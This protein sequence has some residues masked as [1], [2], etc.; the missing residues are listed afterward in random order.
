MKKH[1]TFNFIILVASLATIVEISC[2]SGPAKPT[3]QLL[4]AVK[5]ENV[6][7]VRQLI[8]AG[9]DVNG[10]PNISWKPIHTAVQ[11]KN[12]DIVKLLISKNADVNPWLSSYG[13]RRR[14]PLHMA[15]DTNDLEIAKVLIL[16][17]ADVN[18][19][20]I[21]KSNSVNNA[22]PPIFYARKEM[23][24]LL[25]DSGADVNSR[26]ADA[27]EYTPLHFA[28]KGESYREADIEIV[29]MLID[30]GADVNAASRY[31]ETPLESASKRIQVSKYVWL[32][33]R[34]D[35]ISLLKQHGAKTGVPRIIDLIRKK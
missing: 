35:I 33:P 13:D 17:G 14:T 31:G 26:S 24:K 25:I 15:V 29:K 12:L 10:S 11:K 20:Y 6:Q 28:V 8:S 27:N 2:V 34:Q 16:A 1:P 4:D 5:K 3:L 9:A 21:S 18:A 30:A 32:E 22:C 7:A 23:M 19:K